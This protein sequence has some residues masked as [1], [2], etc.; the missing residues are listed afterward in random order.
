MKKTI[1]KMCAKPKK[2]E[3]KL[4][5]SQID[6]NEEIIL[7]KRIVSG[8]AELKDHPSYK[9]YKS[10]INSENRWLGFSTL[11]VGCGSVPISMLLLREAAYKVD[12]LDSSKRAVLLARQIVGERGYVHYAKAEEFDR[13]DS[14]SNILVTLEAG[15]S[16]KKKQAILN[17]IHKQIDRSTTVIV[18]SSNTDDFINVHI[19][20]GAW[21]VCESFDIFDG[22]S[23]SYVL[24]KNEAPSKKKRNAIYK[25][26][27]KIVC[28]DPRVDEGMCFYLWQR[29][30]DIDIDLLP[31]LDQYRPLDCCES[32]WAPC[33]YEGWETRIEWIVQ[34]IKDT[35]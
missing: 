29:P 18:R 15:D 9:S 23:R 34:A 20:E 14:Y 27:L 4:T 31:E 19:D 26:L 5:P 3:K 8:E 21:E 6:F 16:Q 22:L 10:T 33:T 25:K 35:E 11:V 17:N 28:D 7:A 13:Y 24:Y 32:Y 30:F 2:A 12:G 1:P